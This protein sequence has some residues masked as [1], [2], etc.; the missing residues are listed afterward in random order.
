MLGKLTLQELSPQLREM[1]SRMNSGEFDEI[2]I[3]DHAAI[4]GN[5][6]VTGYA[7][8]NGDIRYNNLRTISGNV[9][10]LNPTGDF[11][12]R[13]VQNTGTIISGS[14]GTIGGNLTVNGTT[15]MTGAATCNSTIR[16]NTGFL[17]GATTVIDNSR[18]VS[19]V[20]VNATG[21]VVAN[22]LQATSDMRIGTNTVIN[23]SRVFTGTSYRIEANTV[24]DSNRDMFARN[25]TATGTITG[26]TVVGAVYN[27]YA[28]YRLAKESI[29][30]GRIV[31]EAEGPYVK[32]SETR[33][34]KAPMMVTDT[35]GMIIGETDVKNAVAIPIAV[36]GRVLAY[37]DKDRST[38]AVGDAVC[39]GKN[40]TV[41]K[42]KWYEKVI[43]PDRILGVVSEIPDYDKWGTNQVNVN[44]RIWINL[45]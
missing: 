15:L 19:A 21:N 6:T 25:V 33:H 38:F 36:A 28:E 34:Q 30:P 4:G 8:I 14:H 18:N 45:K 11:V 44:G 27:D 16:A 37:T 7:Q 22:R 35:C 26:N 13:N 2:A 12:G 24:I 40:G 43:Y 23:S 1:I 20:N 29:E 32:L 10:V 31:V 42:M 5:L 3:A 17:I 39:T 9:H 41:S